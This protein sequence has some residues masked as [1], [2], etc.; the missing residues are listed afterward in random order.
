MSVVAFT[1]GAGAAQIHMPSLGRGD[2]VL[3]SV[4]SRRPSGR[5]SCLIY[6]VGKGW[7]CLFSEKAPGGFRFF[8]TLAAA[9]VFAQAHHLDYHIIRGMPF[10]A[11]LRRRR[12][13]RSSGR[14]RSTFA[15]K[16]WIIFRVKM[17]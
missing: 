5:P 11:A 10:L 16:S 13:D 7:G 3:N 6:P 12:S 15:R 9:I 17:F 4:R 14:L 1:A 8:L 2:G